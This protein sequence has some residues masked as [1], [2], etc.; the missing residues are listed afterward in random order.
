[1]YPYYM[2][3][4]QNDPY[5]PKPL[6]SDFGYGSIMDAITPPPQA[7][8]SYGGG[9][10]KPAAEGN[11]L[12][13][14]PIPYYMLENRYPSDEAYQNAMTMVNPDEEDAIDY[15][16]LLGMTGPNDKLQVPDYSQLG[17]QAKAEDSLGK[18]QGLMSMMPQQQAPSLGPMYANEY[19]N[20][21]MG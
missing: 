2:Q 5:A 4:A 16:K 13:T 21:L 15:D 9:V 6:S 20:S 18:L 10:T 11:G 19:I 17:L 12:M 3:E 1:M 8:Y 14:Y 7:P